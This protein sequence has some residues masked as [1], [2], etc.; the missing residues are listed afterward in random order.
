MAERLMAWADEAPD[1]DVWVR[2]TRPA[3]KDVAVRVGR[4]TILSGLKSS[5]WQT[6]DGWVAVEFDPLG[7]P[8]TSAEG[9]I[10]LYRQLLSLLSPEPDAELLWTVFTPT[11]N[12]SGHSLTKP[13]GKAAAQVLDLVRRIDGRTGPS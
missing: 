12:V 4:R 8:S 11:P 1:Q 13:T 5:V 7:L 3:D 6:P 9:Q 2:V 10:V